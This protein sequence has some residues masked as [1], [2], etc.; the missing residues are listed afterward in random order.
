MR[1]VLNKTKLGRMETR[2]EGSVVWL[3]V[4]SC[5]PFAIQLLPEL[6]LCM[7]LPLLYDYLGKLSSHQSNPTALIIGVELS[8]LQKSKN[9]LESTFKV[10]AQTLF[11]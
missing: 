10:S 5:F 4:F 2:N 3:L 11:P 7:P 8:M 1:Q 9:F 6:L